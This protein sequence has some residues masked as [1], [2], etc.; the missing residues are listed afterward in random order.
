MDTKMRIYNMISE[1]GYRV[2][3]QKKA[4]I[5]V[6]V[7]NTDRM[8]SVGD[9]TRLMDA[10]ADYAT[11]FRNV[12]HFMDLGVL[13]SMM[14]NKGNSRYTLQDSEHHHYLICTECGCIVKFHC[15]NPFWKDFAREK[16]FKET[17]HILEVY[18]ICNKCRNITT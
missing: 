11:V 1:K 3:N 10:P 7:D 2:T 6:L 12:R 17:Y 15:D 9:I 18:G 14:D 4:V 13:E 16:S 5:D 8:L